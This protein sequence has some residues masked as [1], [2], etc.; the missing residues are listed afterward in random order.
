M[1]HIVNI[2]TNNKAISSVDDIVEINKND[3]FVIDKLSSLS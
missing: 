3:L 2:I 1:N